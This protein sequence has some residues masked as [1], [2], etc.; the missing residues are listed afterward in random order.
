MSF[1]S[2]LIGLIILEMV[3]LIPCAAGACVKAGKMY[4]QGANRA[5]HP[6]GA[7]LS[8]F[9]PIYLFSGGTGRSPNVKHQYRLLI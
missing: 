9:P 5:T 3:R 7:Q 6:N 8:V 1:V 2:L 4:Q